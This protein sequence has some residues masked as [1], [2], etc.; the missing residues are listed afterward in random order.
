[1]PRFL[2]AVLCFAA[3]ACGRSSPA[4]P[5]QTVNITGNW[6][7][8]ISS[9]RAGSGTLLL[10]LDQQCLV[11]L[12]PGNGCQWQLTGKWTTLF[13]NPANSDSGTVSGS[14]QDSTTQFSLVRRD[15]NICPFL[16]TATVNHGASINGKFGGQA[17]IAIM[18]FPP[19]DSGTVSVTKVE[20]SAVSRAAAR[21][22][23][24]ASDGAAPNPGAGTRR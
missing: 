3:I 15:T 12:P 18:T 20:G 7:G 6:S 2:T 8:A 19:P 1:M 22:L 4:A 5:K 9:A 11:L 24:S 23:P 17:C 13:S 10:I 14:V 16:V 21:S